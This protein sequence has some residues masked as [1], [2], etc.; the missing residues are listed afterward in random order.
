[1]RYHQTET[2][3]FSM[4]REHKA[5]LA[6]KDRLRESGIKFTEIGGHMEQSIEVHTNGRFVVNDDGS[7]DKEVTNGN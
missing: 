5:C 3:S 2:Y 1:M 6:F 4:P 7:F